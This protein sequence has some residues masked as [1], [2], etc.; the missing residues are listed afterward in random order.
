MER[1]FRASFTKGKTAVTTPTIVI[2][3]RPLSGLSEPDPGPGLLMA[4]CSAGASFTK[5]NISHNLSKIR[6]FLSQLSHMLEAVHS[7]KDSE[8]PCSGSGWW[9]RQ[10]CPSGFFFLEM[11]LTRCRT[12]P[13]K[14]KIPERVAVELVS[15]WCRDGHKP[16]F[17]HPPLSEKRARLLIILNIFNSL[18]QQISHASVPL[19]PAS[20][21]I[22]ASPCYH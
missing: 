17:R 14:K 4:Y 7:L 1:P 13:K 6:T 8:P 11:V 2:P 21:L 15:P 10:M 16:S 19:W 18:C 3:K 5:K 22:L 12:P 20:C 9:M